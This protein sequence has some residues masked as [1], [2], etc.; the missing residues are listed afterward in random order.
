[1]N[2]N[3]SVNL[4][5]QELLSESNLN[6][7][8]RRMV[9]DYYCPYPDKK[10]QSAKRKK[11]SKIE[12]FADAKKT[13]KNKP[14]KSQDTFAIKDALSFVKKNGNSKKKFDKKIYEYNRTKVINGIKEINKI[15]NSKSK[16]KQKFIKIENILKKIRK[17]HVLKKGNLTEKSYTKA[18]KSAYLESNKLKSF[19]AKKFTN[20][21][22]V[23]MRGVK[24]FN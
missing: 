19:D 9:Y 8:F 18:W 24:Y 2:T 3:Q 5:K 10:R 1:M 16:P 14:Q 23:M 6:V 4:V 15:L 21:Q 17:F 12:G 22:R 11:L 20:A 7:N 13:F